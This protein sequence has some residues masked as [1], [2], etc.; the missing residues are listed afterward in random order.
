MSAI[1]DFDLL[2]KGM[3]NFHFVDQ[4]D[5]IQALKKSVYGHW[6]QF[7]RLSSVLWFAH[8]KK[9]PPRNKKCASVSNDFGDLWGMEFDEWAKT[10]ARDLFPERKPFP[11][12]RTYSSST[13]I[14][15]EERVIVVPMTILRSSLLKQFKAFLNTEHPGNLLNVLETAHS[16]KYRIHTKMYR[17]T[18]LENERLVLIYRL[19][20]PE[21]PV[22]VI[23]DRLQL[24]P[25]NKVR[26]EGFH[27]RESRKQDFARLNSVGGRYLYKARRRLLNLE[28]GSFPNAEEIDVSQREQPFGR[29]LH[30]EFVK[31]TELTMKRRSRWQKWLW[32]EYKWEL[33][34]TVK[35]RNPYN[36]VPDAVEDMVPFLS[37]KPYVPV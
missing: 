13:E 21:T 12:I 4:D 33:E 9:A 18:V 2:Y 28:R 30:P 7:A 8:M 35:E 22:W 27:I 25:S 1:I 6:H 37:G 15:S 26:D 31:Q 11:S 29:A 34:H 24:A 20:Y 32:N 17:D 36:T 23:A 14:A 19:L 3:R 5:E 16:A 10:R